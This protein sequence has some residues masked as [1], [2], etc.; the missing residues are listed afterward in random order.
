METIT[1]SKW[2]NRT[3]TVD[4]FIISFTCF[5]FLWTVK[6]KYNQV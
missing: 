1:Q 3:T 5:R 4:V 2:Y 6:D